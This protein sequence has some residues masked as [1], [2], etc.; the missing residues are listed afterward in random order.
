MRSSIIVLDHLNKIDLLVVRVHEK[1]L[2]VVRVR[3][4]NLRIYRT[5]VPNV[6]VRLD[7]PNHPV[8]VRSRHVDLEI[9]PVN[10]RSLHVVL[11]EEVNLQIVPTGER[12][13]WLFLLKVI[14]LL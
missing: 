6:K 3:E 2:R 1:N 12:D 9:H 8:N 11:A 4:K 14:N 5:K 7:L 13:S 10:I